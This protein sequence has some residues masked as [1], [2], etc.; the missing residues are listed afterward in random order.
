MTSPSRI[1]VTCLFVACAL[2]YASP[3]LLAVNEWA[4]LSPQAGG[5]PAK[6]CNPRKGPCPDTAAPTVTIVE[7]VTGAT[8]A[9][10]VTI[11]GTASD[12]VGVARVE[13]QVDSAPFTGADG[14]AAWEFV[15]D[16]SLYADGVHS[17]SARAV[18]AAGN[19]SPARSISV[20]I[21]NT[22]PD[23]IV[24]DV[25]QARLD[26]PT[27]HALGVQV[28]IAGDAN[29]NGAIGVRYRESGTVQWR[30]GPP[31]MRVFPGNDV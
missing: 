12:N 1:L 5:K 31:L 27:V 13:V 7:P 19:I 22:G 17:V 20:T 21:N 11:A 23:P 29:R 28:L 15:L 4:N 26:P 14:T 10:P 8:V 24:L 25:Q 6:P 3:N 9:G 30:Q 18:D 2:L 16:T